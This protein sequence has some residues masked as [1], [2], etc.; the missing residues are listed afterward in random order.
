MEWKNDTPNEIKEIYDSC[1]YIYDSCISCPSKLNRKRAESILTLIELNYGK[2]KEY[3]FHEALRLCMFEGR[4]FCWE[5]NNEIQMQRDGL[6][7]ADEEKRIFRITK[8]DLEAKWIEVF[9]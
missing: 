4:R 7:I 2:R 3:D 5:T 6:N 9:E 8:K 1:E